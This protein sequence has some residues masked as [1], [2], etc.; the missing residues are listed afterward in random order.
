MRD[1]GLDGEVRN[2]HRRL[3]GLE[4]C[5]LATVLANVTRQEGTVS[6]GT[7]GHIEFALPR[8]GV[9]VVVDTGSRLT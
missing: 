7:K 3:I 6:N 8:T 4:R 1:K 5:S 9:H 2:G